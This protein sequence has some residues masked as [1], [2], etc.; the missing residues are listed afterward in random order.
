MSV[1]YIFSQDEFIENSPKLVEMSDT[2]IIKELVKSKKQDKDKLIKSLLDVLYNNSDPD[3]IASQFS[4]I[5]NNKHDVRLFSLGLELGRRRYQ[6]K[7]SYKITSPGNAVKYLEPYRKE[8]QENFIMIALNSAGEIIKIE[9]ITLGLIN[10]TVIHSRELFSR[11]IEL[12]AVNIIIAH[13]H[14]TGD[15]NPSLNDKNTTSML[16]NA[17]KI[18]GIKILDHIIIGN[19]DDSNYYSFANNGLIE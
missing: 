3:Y 7:T 18:I 12:R 1:N 6:K 2:S 5:L 13:N 17:G 4:S 9:T 19:E 8:S 11:A 10:Q 16:V 14:P 15:T